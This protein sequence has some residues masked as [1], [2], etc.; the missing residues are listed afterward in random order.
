LWAA[1]IAER[2]GFER[3][4][5]LTLGKVVAGLTA[6]S[7]GQRLGIFTQSPS[8]VRRTRADE[9]R[10]AGAFAIATN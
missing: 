5:A 6:Q 10:A 8:A 7:K 3:D 1:V 2:L 9:A 4:E